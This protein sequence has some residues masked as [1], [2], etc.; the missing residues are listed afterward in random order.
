LFSQLY[1]LTEDHINEILKKVD[2]DNNGSIE[3]SEFLAHS[4]TRKQL[5]EKNIQSFFNIMLPEV[6]SN[7]ISRPSDTPAEDIEPTIN[8]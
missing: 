7:S 6:K 3:Y 4:M 2:Q 8:A 5:S 1:E